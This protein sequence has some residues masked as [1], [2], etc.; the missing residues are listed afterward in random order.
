MVLL[1][2]HNHRLR[3]LLERIQANNRRI[4]GSKCKWRYG[5]QLLWP[6][7]AILSTVSSRF[8]FIW[9]MFVN[10]RLWG[11]LL[12][13]NKKRICMLTFYQ[14]TSNFFR[15]WLLQ[16]LHHVRKPIKV[17]KAHRVRVQVLRR[18]SSIINAKQFPWLVQQ[19]FQQLVYTYTQRRSDRFVCT[20][21]K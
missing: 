18:S 4:L 14:N 7:A 20:C 16:L 2:I 12:I 15:G 21:W 17:S 19:P 9:T 3:A 1:S 10:W 5:N 13:H 11:K 6:D 8:Q